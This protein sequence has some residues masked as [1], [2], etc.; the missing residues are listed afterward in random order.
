MGRRNV[1]ID[2]ES[3]AGGE[4]WKLGRCAR[5][6]RQMA[7]GENAEG[8]ARGWIGTV[9]GGAGGDA[10]GDGAG[11]GVGDGQKV[12]GKLEGRWPEMEEVEMVVVRRS[13]GGGGGGLRTAVLR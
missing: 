5:R 8:V 10:R 3:G 1:R 6:S 13:G 11:G 9:G 12:E 7:G 2:A 4:E